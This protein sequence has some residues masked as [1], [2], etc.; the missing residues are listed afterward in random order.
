MG[1]R[2]Y[3][4][5]LSCCHWSKT[6]QGFILCLLP[7]SWLSIIWVYLTCFLLTLIRRIHSPELSWCSSIRTSSK[8][9]DIIT[10]YIWFCIKV[11]LCRQQSHANP[12]LFYQGESTSKQF[13][14]YVEEL[15]LY[16]QQS[17]LKPLQNNW[18]HWNKTVKVMKYSRKQ[19]GF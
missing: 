11:I 15:L 3:Q 8:W 9:Y 7:T 12:H 17:G 1:R 18:L 13:N 14:P 10:V 16:L 19:T 2:S 6:L 5:R 4:T